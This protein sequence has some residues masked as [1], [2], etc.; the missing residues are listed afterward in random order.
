MPQQVKENDMESSIAPTTL[1]PPD[2]QRGTMKAIV[3]ERYGRPDVL[4]LREVDMPVIEDHQVLV[5]VLASSVNPAEWYQ[6]T[7]PYFARVADGLRKPK[8]ARI[9]ADL[10]GR[11]EAVGKDV[12][13]FQPGDEVFGTSGAS[14][15]EYAP[16]REARLVRKPANVSFEEAAAVP[17]AALTALQ[18]LRD[19]GRVQPGHKVLINGASGGVGTYAVQLAKSF[20]ADVTAVCSTGNVEQARSLGADRVL[21]YTREDFTQL[22]ER[23][24]LMLDIAGSRP[25]SQVRRVLTPEATI[26]LVGGRMTYRGHGPLPHLVKMRLTSLGRS[27]SVANFLAKITKED[28]DL[29]RQLLEAGTVRSVID[30]RYALGEVSDA[31]RYLGETHAKGKVVITV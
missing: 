18:A 7:G 11:I 21:D 29:M 2:V 26:V 27:Q 8:S 14:W 3:H 30:R 25:F 22:G 4:E 17:V 15:A 28:L 19:K 5:R 6:V 9:G 23:H 24:D 1:P 31:L 12:K 20:G 10:A 16:A 13:E